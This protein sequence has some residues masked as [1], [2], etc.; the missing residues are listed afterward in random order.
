[1]NKEQQ[2]KEMADE[3]FNAGVALDGVDFAY[4]S[5]H[6]DRL[7]IKLYNAGYRKQTDTVKEFAEQLKSELSGLTTIIKEI[8]KLAEQRIKERK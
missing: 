6:F 1:M 8:D 5:D 4:K 2:I 7:A 3:I